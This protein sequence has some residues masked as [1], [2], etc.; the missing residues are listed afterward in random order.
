M[1]SLCRT[2]FTR[3]RRHTYI[4]PDYAYVDDD[5]VKRFKHRDSYVQLLREMKQ[6]R[7]N[8]KKVKY[9]A[10]LIYLLT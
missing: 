8:R 2:I 9:V 4:D 7:L 3:E 1:L 5:D 6:I 10:L